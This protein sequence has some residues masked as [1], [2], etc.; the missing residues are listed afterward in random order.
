LPIN[1]QGGA[2]KLKGLSQDGGRAKL[3]KNLCG[4]KDLTM[5]SLSARCISMNSFIKL[6]LLF[7]HF[8]LPLYCS[9]SALYASKKIY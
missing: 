4:Y 7:Y 8:L 5:K 6:V 9:T 1:L 2:E 3:A